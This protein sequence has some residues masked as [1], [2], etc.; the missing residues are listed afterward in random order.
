MAHNSEVEQEEIQTKSDIIW[1]TSPD[2]I[3]LSYIARIRPLHEV[4]YRLRKHFEKKDTVPV[5][6]REKMIMQF[7]NR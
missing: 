2:R 3:S 5:Y 6:W 1:R 7:V 4:Y